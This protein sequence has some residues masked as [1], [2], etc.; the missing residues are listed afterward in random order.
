MQA[1]EWAVMYPEVV[2]SVIP[3]ATATAHS[4]W[5]IGFNDASRSAIIDD[6]QWSNGNYTDQPVAGL[7]LARKIAMLSYRSFPSFLD[8][9]G[10]EVEDASDTETD[11]KFLVETYL[12]YQGKS[13]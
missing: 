8:K 12:D 10:R 11:P 3:I 1:L 13:L 4:P 5:A 2:E 6:P 7:S 9:F